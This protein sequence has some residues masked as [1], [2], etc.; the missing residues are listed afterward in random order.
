MPNLA[1]GGGNPSGFNQSGGVA[2]IPNS[3]QLGQ[4][5]G[6]NN[7]L[8]APMPSQQQWPGVSSPYSF[9]ANGTSAPMGGA[10]TGLNPWTSL[11]LDKTNSNNLFRAFKDAGVPSGL[12]E[13]MAGFMGSGAGFNPQVL[14]AIFASLQPQIS[15]GQSDIMEQFGSQGLGM[16]SPAAIGMGDFMSQV[17]LNEGQ[18]ASQLYEQSIQNYMKVLLGGSGYSSQDHPGF[19]QSLGESL[20]SSGIKAGLSGLGGG[21]TSAAGGGSFGG[22]FASG[23]GSALGG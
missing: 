23:F 11:G 13:A 3:G 16:S 1:A 21:I 18:I 4:V 10:P 12:A 2:P 22:G 17:N 9:A 19:F 5:G 6:N 14:N 20:L 8:I 7:P 15:R